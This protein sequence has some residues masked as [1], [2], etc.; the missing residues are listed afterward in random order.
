MLANRK[1]VVLAS[2]GQFKDAVKTE[3]LAYQ[4]YAKLLGEEHEMTKRSGST[5]QVSRKIVC[6][7]YMET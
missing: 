3:K 6:R 4:F 1:A 7:F 5:L 2:L